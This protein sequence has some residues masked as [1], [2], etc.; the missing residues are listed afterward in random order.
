[1]SYEFE[2]RKYQVGVVG[3]GKSQFRPVAV[4]SGLGY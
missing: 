1:M 4:K 3:S 2:R